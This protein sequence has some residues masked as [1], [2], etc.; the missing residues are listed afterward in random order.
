[1]FA[2]VSVSIL[3]LDSTLLPIN[4]KFDTVVRHH[5]GLIAF[6]IG[7]SQSVLLEDASSDGF[8]TWQGGRTLLRPACFRHFEKQH[9]H[10]LVIPF[11]DSNSNT[12]SPVNFK[13]EW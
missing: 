11:S 6:K 4:L 13:C 2:C 8:E 7:A 1:M 3:F 10:H 12:F 9:C 5:R